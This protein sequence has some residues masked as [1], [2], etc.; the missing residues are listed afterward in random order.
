MRSQNSFFKAPGYY[1]T[2][3]SLQAIL[4][5][6]PRYSFGIKY[7]DPKPDDTP[8]MSLEQFFFSK[9]LIP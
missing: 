6:S 3:K 7:K 5:S 9:L 4:G 8:G 1:E 2:E